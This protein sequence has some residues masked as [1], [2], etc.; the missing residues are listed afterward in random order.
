MSEYKP[1]MTSEEVC[2]DM[3]ACGL[4]MSTPKF[5]AMVLQ[6]HFSEFAKAVVLKKTTFLIFRKE[7]EAWKM[8][9]DLHYI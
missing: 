8:E 6:G 3:R 1:T 7:Y 4:K 2:R 5:R 9:H